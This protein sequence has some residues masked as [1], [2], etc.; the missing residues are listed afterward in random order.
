MEQRYEKIMVVDDSNL[1]QMVTAD[2]LKSL[3]FKDILLTGD[4][5][6]A[7]NKYNEEKPKLILIDINLP[8]KSGLEL[9]EDIRKIDKT[10]KIII[11]S[12]ISVQEFE[13]ELEENNLEKSDQDNLTMPLFLTKPYSRDELLSAIKKLLNI[14]R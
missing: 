3:G 5:E 2:N 9:M 7:L 13:K 4:Y 11:Q 12:C 1:Q 8:G 14:R 10:V 6:S